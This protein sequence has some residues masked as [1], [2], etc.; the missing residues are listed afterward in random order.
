MGHADAALDDH[1]YGD[2]EDGGAR[3]QL[4]FGG[5]VQDIR[6]GEQCPNRDG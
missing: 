1:G 4:N 5:Q 2:V 6:Q 3:E